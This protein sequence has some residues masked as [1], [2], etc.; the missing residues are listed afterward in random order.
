MSTGLNSFS[1]PQDIGALYPGAGN[2]WLMVLIGFVL[3]LL[4]HIFQMADEEKE[5]RDAVKLYQQVGMERAM[6][7]ATGKVATEDEV[8]IS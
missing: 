6:H 2:E 1:N 7:H 5:Y 3:W 8:H 4:W